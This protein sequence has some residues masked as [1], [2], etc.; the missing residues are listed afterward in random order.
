MFY[1]FLKRRIKKAQARLKEDEQSAKH[2]HE[3]LNNAR[4]MLPLLVGSKHIRCLDL[5]RQ[6]ETLVHARSDIV[7]HNRAVLDAMMLA[8][9]T[10]EAIDR[11]RKDR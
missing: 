5:L 4:D 1:Y 6:F 7:T 8:L 3:F 11:I 10:H 9:K 2:A